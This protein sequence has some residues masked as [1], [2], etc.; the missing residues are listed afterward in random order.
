MSCK[1]SPD[2]VRDEVLTAWRCSVVAYGRKPGRDGPHD[3]AVD[4][5]VSS[6]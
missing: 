5:A 6:P 4:L 2:G 1:F 3:S